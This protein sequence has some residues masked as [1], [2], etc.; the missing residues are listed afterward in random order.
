LFDD[1]FKGLYTSDPCVRMRSADVIEKVTRR[2]PEYLEKWRD[3][4]T[5]RSPLFATHLFFNLARYSGISIMG[6]TFVAI[7][8]CDMRLVHIGEDVILDHLIKSVIVHVDNAAR[9]HPAAKSL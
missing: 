5:Q 4:I 7:N 3:T 2:H 8:S 6:G 1:V 9:L